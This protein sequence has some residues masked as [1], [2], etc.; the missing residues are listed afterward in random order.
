MMTCREPCPIDP[1]VR[2]RVGECVCE[3]VAQALDSGDFRRLSYIPGDALK[4]ALQRT[5]R[6]AWRQGVNNG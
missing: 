4:K 5:I 1:R 2:E 3:I 6:R